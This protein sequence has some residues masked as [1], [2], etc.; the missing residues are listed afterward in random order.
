MNSNP[1]KTSMTFFH[2]LITFENYEFIWFKKGQYDFKGL[3]DFQQFGYFKGLLTS[4]TSI[5]LKL[6][7]TTSPVGWCGGLVGGWVDIES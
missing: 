5:D 3:K 6:K 2:N 1:F 4:K 7:F